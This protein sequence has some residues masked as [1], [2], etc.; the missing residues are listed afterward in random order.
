[1][2]VLSN[3][4]CQLQSLRVISQSLGVISP[5]LNFVTR[6]FGSIH[7]QAP[8]VPTSDRVYIFLEYCARFLHQLFP[9]DTFVPVPSMS[10][11]L[12]SS[13]I[14]IEVSH[15]FFVGE[16][17][18][19]PSLNAYLMRGLAAGAVQEGGR[20][21]GLR[22]ADMKEGRRRRPQLA[23][24]GCTVENKQAPAVLF[25]PT[26]TRT[27]KRGER[28]N[29]LTTNTITGCFMLPSGDRTIDLS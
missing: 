10:V 16:K 6:R 27:H 26:H 17:R 19:E 28:K 22:L 15:P 20:G 11:F 24:D 29:G 9:S 8:Q 25:W 1:M 4:L 12:S 3:I 7:H 23:M 18:G 5:C 21:R 2:I 14:P 13:E